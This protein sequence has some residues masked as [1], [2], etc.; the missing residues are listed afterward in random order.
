MKSKRSIALMLA[1]LLAASLPL[2]AKEFDLATAS[3]KDINEAIDA[4]ALSSEKLVQLYLNRIAAYD[5]A[6]PK[7]NTI[8]TLNPDALALARALDE[9]RKTK[10][11]RSPLHDIPAIV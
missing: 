2:A 8:I 7:L 11:R 1:A 9:A 10:G 3:I 5:Q 6:G 4:G